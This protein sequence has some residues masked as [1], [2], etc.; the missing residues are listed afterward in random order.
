MR[1]SADG[2]RAEVL[3]EEWPVDLVPAL[4]DGEPVAFDPA[5]LAPGRPLLRGPI[6]YWSA[7]VDS[8]ERLYG[9]G[10]DRV[11]AVAVP[12]GGGMLIRGEF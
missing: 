11:H 7:V 10:S 2:R 3:A 8:N 1:V 12:S 6:P 4:L 5:R 9:L